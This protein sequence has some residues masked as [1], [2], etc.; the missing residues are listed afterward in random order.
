MKVSILMATYNHAPFISQAISSV[1]MQQVDFE[2]EL[3]IGEDCSTDGT[4][5][6]VIDFANR[7]P[8]IIKPV[9][10]SVNLGPHGNGLKMFPFIRGEYIAL[11]DGDDY[12]T[13]PYKLKKQVSLL[14]SNPVYSMCFTN[15]TIVDDENKTTKKS[16]VPVDKQR[17]LSQLDIISG[18]CPPSNTYLVRTSLIM[19]IPEAWK[20][21]INGDFVIAVHSTDHGPAGYLNETTAAYRKHEKGIWSTKSEIYN[22]VNFAKTCQALLTVY[23]D[24]Y[25]DILLKHINNCYKQLL[26]MEAGQANNSI[27]QP[28]RVVQEPPPPAKDF[29][30]NGLWTPQTCMLQTLQRWVKTA[31][32]SPQTALSIDNNPDIDSMLQEKWPSISITRASYPEHDVQNL[33]RFGSNTFDIVYSHQVLEHV[34]KPWL[35]GREIV[36]VLKQGGIGIHTSCAFNPRHGQ[37]A[38]NDYYRFLPD[39]LA[40]LFDGVHVLEKGEWGNRQAILYNVGIDDGHGALGGRRFSKTIGE[41]SDGLYPWHTWI[42][43]RKI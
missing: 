1:L 40:E 26:A 28:P 15:S 38:F 41:A 4:R 11:I 23:R 30:D 32:F 37:P 43:F 33:Y 25:E 18:Y 12:W 27:A 9:L 20:K 16:R 34:P 36:R 42:I 5:D 22:Q 7:F 14:D 2:Y 21:C 3:I 39:G 35:A 8:H 17:P 31:P 13:D 10:H 6:I 19:P 29:T 24:K